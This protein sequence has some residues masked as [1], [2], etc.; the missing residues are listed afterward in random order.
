MVRNLA[1]LLAVA[2]VGCATAYPPSPVIIDVSPEAYVVGGVTLSTP[3]ELKT[4]LV[5]R[6]IRDV[7]MVLHRDVSWARASETLSAV[8]DAGA[9]IGITGSTNFRE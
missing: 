4:Y 5:E 1:A 7:R 3:V 8:R 6:R 9:S 2:S